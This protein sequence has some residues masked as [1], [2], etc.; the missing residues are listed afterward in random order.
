MP[1]S[2]VAENSIVWCVAVDAVE[3]L[4]HLGQEPHVGHAVGLVED[5]HLHRGERQLAALHEVDETA[6]RADDDVD[7][8]RSASTWR[9]HADAAVERATP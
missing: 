8:A 3:D 1:R 4:L 6:G 5:E 7:A 9:L 2:S